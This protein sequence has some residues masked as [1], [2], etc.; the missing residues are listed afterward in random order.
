[1]KVNCKRCGAETEVDDR[2]AEALAKAQVHAPDLYVGP[3]PT[4]G[5]D[6]VRANCL[7]A[8]CTAWEVGELLR[9]GPPQA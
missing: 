8:T 3:V 1:M 9:K 2:T 4:V 7:C 5:M 6:W